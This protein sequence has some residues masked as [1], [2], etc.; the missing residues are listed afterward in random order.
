M[1]AP[2]KP[3]RL[4]HTSVSLLLTARCPDGGADYLPRVIE[5]RA[6]RADTVILCA[7]ELQSEADQQ[8][9][10]KRGDG[11][12][13]AQ[14]HCG[15]QRLHGLGE[16]GSVALSRGGGEMALVWHFNAS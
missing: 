7:E 3:A 14:L 9:L 8:R 15:A 10:E 12:Q 1:R 5:E 2:F 6:A 13:D 11:E 4:T 16:A